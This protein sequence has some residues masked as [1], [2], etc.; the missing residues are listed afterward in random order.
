MR[1]VNESIRHVLAYAK[2]VNPYAA[3]FNIVTPYPGTGFIKEIRDQIDTFDWSRYDVYTPNLK[4]Q[5]FT[6]E[7]IS[8]YHRKCF[9]QYYFRF[10]WLT[11]NWRLMWPRLYR[12]MEPL[13]PA[14]EFPIQASKQLA[15]KP[16]PEKLKL[17]A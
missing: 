16:Q 7:E 14:Q 17:V 1:R 12:L 10:G 13:L 6:A 11:E 8:E 5:N 2:K 9:R 15:A 4:Y 3:N